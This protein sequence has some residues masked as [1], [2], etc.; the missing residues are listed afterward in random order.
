MSDLSLLDRLDGFD[1]RFSEVGTLITDPAVI[2][3]MPRYVRLSKEY[4]ELEKITAA[5][6]RYR[7]LI[8]GIDEAREMLETEQDAELR[9]LWPVRSSKPRARRF[10]LSKRR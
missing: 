1:A 5:A 10:R 6:R 9:T 3:D 8:A 4:R 7:Q 2:A